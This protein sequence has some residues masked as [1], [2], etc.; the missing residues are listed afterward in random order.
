MVAWFEMRLLFYPKKRCLALITAA[1]ALAVFV[2]S[3]CSQGKLNPPEQGLEIGTQTQLLI[4]DFILESTQALERNL[5]PL[6]KHEGNPLLRPERPWE[7]QYTLP[8]TVLYDDSDGLF[9]MWYS[10]LEERWR[11][12]SR[13]SRSAYAVSRDGISWERPQLGLA[14]YQGSRQN[15]LLP[16]NVGRVFLDTR[17]TEPSRRFKAVG[18]GR[19]QEGEP[20][21][22]LIS[23]SADGLAWT[24]HP[25]NPL[26]SQPRGGGTHPGIGDTHTILGW[27]DH[28]GRYV[29][30]M[31]PSSRFRD[32]GRSESS[33]FIDW[34][35]PT[36]VLVP[37]EL[38]PPGT[39]FYGM[40]VVR[41][42]GIYL[43]LLWVYHPNS[44]M[45]DVQL[46]F[47][48]D[49]V[50]WRRLGRRHPILT[51]G[52]PHEFDSHMLLGLKPLVV[53]D[54]IRVYYAAENEAHALTRQDLPLLTHPPVSPPESLSKQSWL[55][56]RRGFGGLAISRR[57]GF[58]SLDSGSPLG[59]LVTKPFTLRGQKLLINLDASMGRCRVEI[60]DSQG[61]SVEGFAASDSD[62]FRGDSLR[63]VA[64][65]KGK[66]DLSSLQGEAIKVK[67]LMTNTK[68]YSFTVS[69][70][71]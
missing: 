24:P 10:C 28:W 53:G 27:D 38:D 69:D 51:Y 41:D 19:V 44:L 33:D 22:L 30:Y 15:N 50:G 57:D 64:S 29:A 37:D 5:N 67:L 39:Q 43:G 35:L 13:K 26:L 14:S 49:G 20:A 62:I 46:A 58:V 17:E 56:R 23:F 8:S 11:P 31:R 60:Q 55:E 32:I 18:Y 61:N 48:R 40:S 9:K 45:M 1:A 66:R 2:F 71:E 70:K 3:S 7:G 63:H 4:D 65:W 25:D 6:S 21:G 12:H 59:V 34:R 36:P 54:E 52:L 68:L 47:S 42:H 16:D